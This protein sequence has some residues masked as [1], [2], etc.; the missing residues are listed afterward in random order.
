MNKK[1]TTSRLNRWAAEVLYQAAKVMQHS[2]KNA[3]VSV[4]L[5]HAVVVKFKSDQK[6]FQN[7]NIS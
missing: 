4:F 7:N 1:K 5:G 3:L 2:G 6:F